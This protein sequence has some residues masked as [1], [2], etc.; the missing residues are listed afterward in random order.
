MTQEAAASGTTT[1]LPQQRA[2]DQESAADHV[3]ASKSVESVKPVSLDRVLSVAAL[4]PAQAALIAVQLLDAA[5]LTGPDDEEPPVIACLGA[6]TLTSSGD[7]DV[8]RPTAGAGTPVNELLEQLLQNARRLP[9]HPRPEQ[10]VLL[11]RLEEAAG[12]PLLDPGAR[13][14]ELETALADTLGPGS[15]QRLAGQLAA[16]VDAF[17]HVAPGAPVGNVISLAPEPGRAT[18]TPART[19][20]T[21]A[22]PGS[23]QSGPR[24]AAPTRSAPNRAPRRSRVLLHR[25]T[26]GRV[27]LVAIVV[28]AVL[29][30]SGYVVL[31]GP[32]SDIVGSLGRD[33][34]PAAPDTTVPDQPEKQ[35][36]KEPKPDRAQAVPTVAPQ[37][38]GPITGVALEK[39]GSC[40][41]GS[42][43]PVTVTVHFRPASTSRTIGWKVGTAQVCKPGITWSGPV[44]VTAQPGWTTVYASSSVRV[45]KGRQLA[46]TALTTTPARAQSR[47]V[48]ATGSSLQC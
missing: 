8:S 37:Q 2:V 23:S 13:A 26:R 11:H 18:T 15:R 10:L 48:P 43:C 44:T 25:R 16:L 28:A 5:R 19:T 34:N 17:A 45:P 12:A 38:A 31:G 3:R 27:A 41:P 21:S 7:V 29:A 4:T 14:R 40:R 20:G 47:P 33:D 30:V 1:P 35:P 32:G 22:A 46:L 6:V 9:A 39:A 24:R 36:A 42:L